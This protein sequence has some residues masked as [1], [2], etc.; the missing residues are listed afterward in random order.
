MQIEAGISATKATKNIKQ[1]TLFIG[2]NDGFE[3]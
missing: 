3:G 1:I 2:I